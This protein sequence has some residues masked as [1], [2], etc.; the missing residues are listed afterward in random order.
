MS[1][2]PSP[3]E[4]AL[5][6]FNEFLPILGGINSTDWVYFRGEEA[7]KCA[8]VT[9]RELL[10]NNYTDRAIV[11]TD[12]ESIHYTTYVDYYTNVLIEVSKI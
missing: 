9:V 10:K 12:G 3:K 4:K 7:K 5:E 11:Y 6:L 1:N 8:L 2:L